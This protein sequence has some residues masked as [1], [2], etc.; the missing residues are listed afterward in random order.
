MRPLAQWPVVGI[1][2]VCILWILL[3]VVVPLIWVQI[4]LRS[5]VVRLSGSGG[6]AA[7][8]MG[9]DTLVLVLPPAVF[10]LAWFLAR[11]RSRAGQAPQG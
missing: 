11:R 1:M 9:V 6:V 7:V 4:Q 8:S 10:C 3:C 2:V 5:E